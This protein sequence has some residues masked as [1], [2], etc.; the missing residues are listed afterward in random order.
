MDAH[1]AERPRHVDDAHPAGRGGDADAI[2]PK[3]F[4][5]DRL[6]TEFDCEVI[7]ANAWRPRLAV[8]NHYGRG[9]V[10]LA[11]DSTHQF[12]PTG[13]YGMNTGV[14]DAVG[15]GWALAAILQ[16]WGP[17]ACSPPTKPNAGRSRCATGG[18]RP[19][20]LV[21]MAIKTAYRKAIHSEGWAGE[22][23]RRRLAREILDLGNLENEADGIEFGYRYDTSPVIWH[24][25]G[26]APIQTMDAYTPSSWPGARPPSLFLADGRA[27][28]DL[29][30]TG[31]TLLRFA[32]IDVTPIVAAAADREFPW[33][34]S[35]SATATHVSSINATWC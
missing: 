16:G 24:E 26:I 30:G 33:T 18:R 35:T 11:G 13:G 21:R 10:W 6:G 27:I 34:W 2:D 29:F 7:V 22:R 15:L 1:R 17:R 14:G 32:D 4:L 3:Q 20:F 19:H 8:A 31:F 12:I 28:F 23:S 5:F 9:R 25:S